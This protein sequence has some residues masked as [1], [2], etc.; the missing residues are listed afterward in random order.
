MVHAISHLKHGVRLLEEA[1]KYQRYERTG[2]GIVE[3]LLARMS[4]QALLV[5]FPNALLYTWLD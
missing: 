3:A 1:K 4:V 2:S 5:I